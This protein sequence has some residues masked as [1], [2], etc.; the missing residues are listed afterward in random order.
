MDKFF[1]YVFLL[2]LI[3]LLLKPGTKEVLNSV[4]KFSTQGIMALQGRFA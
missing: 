1:W 4:S 2:I 3:F